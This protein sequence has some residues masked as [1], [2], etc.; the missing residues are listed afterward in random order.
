[1]TISETTKNAVAQGGSW[2]AVLIGGISFEMWVA[3]AGLLLSALAYW[4]ASRQR[5]FEREMMRRDELRKEEL[6]ALRLARLGSDRRKRD[7]SVSHERRRAYRK[8]LF[9]GE[10]LEPLD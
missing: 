5:A 6:H 4:S 3:L 2:L 9:E 1:M 10:S 8:D 7:V